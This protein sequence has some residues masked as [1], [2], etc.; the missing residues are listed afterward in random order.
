M[1]CFSPKLGVKICLH[2]SNPK[3]KFPPKIVE[4]S[5]SYIF[6]RPLIFRYKLILP[7]NLVYASMLQSAVVMDQL[8]SPKVAFI[9]SYMYDV[10]HDLH[11]TVSCHL[12]KC[13]VANVNS[14]N[15]N[16]LNDFA[17][18]VSTPNI[19]SSNVNSP[20]FISFYV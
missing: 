11:M 4:S 15:V 18:N 9:R 20:N 13:K 17:P 6:I 10:P 3:R 19:N 7:Q 8:G 12:D 16:S 1:S 14:P 5:A 2:N